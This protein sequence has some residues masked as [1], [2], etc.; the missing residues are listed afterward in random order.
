[1]LHR[2]RKYNRNKNQRP[3][4]FV[5][6]LNDASRVVYDKLSIKQV[7]PV[8]GVTLTSCET[9]NQL[10]QYVDTLSERQ[11]SLGLAK[12]GFS[13]EELGSLPDVVRRLILFDTMSKLRRQ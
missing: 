11:L 4:G 7:K 1:M 10:F 13:D 5:K 6:V 2:G 12:Y 9:P 8:R 3:L